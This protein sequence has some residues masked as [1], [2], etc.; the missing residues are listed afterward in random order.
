MNP[1]PADDIVAAA[2]PSTRLVALV[3]GAILAIA[4]IGYWRTGMP[5][6]AERAVLV[7]QQA[8]TQAAATAGTDVQQLQAM[9]GRL[10]EHLK[11]KPDDGEGWFMLGRAQSML[12][13]ADAALAA[14]RRAQA[15]RGDDPK[16]LTDIAEVLGISKGHQ[17]AGEPTELLAKALAL[18]PKAPKT[19]ALSGAAAFDRK[20]Y[21]QAVKHWET[22]LQASPA[23]AAFVAQVRDGITEARRL[24]NLPAP[25][26][27][28]AA[29]PAAAPV[30]AAAASIS[31]TVTLAA[32][33][34]AQAAPE[35]T[36]FVFA[37]A[38]EGPRMPLAML[39]KQVK[40]LPITF[41]LDDSQA[42]SPQMK[43]SAF[44]KVIVVARIS[45]SG[46]A[47]P[48]PGD[49][50][51]QSDPVALGARGLGIEVREVMK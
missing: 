32:A 20:D 19:L 28:L 33:L 22:L 7:E 39:K 2:R 36:V 23:D 24:G 38:A 29:A 35:D 12:G 51:G 18:D 3:A 31:G 16:L 34:K 37:R 9:A 13:R 48:Q 25:A 17:L 26:A 49:L 47:T 14:Y 11:S 6:Y 40:D 44:P 10:E 27:A 1:K 15:F 5:D 50:G 21:A 45:K 41:T 43:L 4:A 30:A 8:A 46:Q 42:M